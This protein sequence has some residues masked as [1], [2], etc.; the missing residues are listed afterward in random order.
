MAD[1]TPDLRDE[2][3]ANALRPQSTSTDG[4]TIVERSIDDQIKADKYLKS[5]NA[6]T[7]PNFGL[8]FARII[9]PRTA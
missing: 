6:V 4:E 9:P 2:L 1:E 5:E 7:G 8:A 3:A